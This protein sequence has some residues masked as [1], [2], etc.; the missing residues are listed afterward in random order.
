MKNLQNGIE[1]SLVELKQY[2]QNRINVNVMTYSEARTL[3]E[4]SHQLPKCLVLRQEVNPKNYV[5]KHS[6]FNVE[7][8]N[9]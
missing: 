2:G 9:T 1:L 4:G 6:T 8:E 5:G 7:N 3:Y